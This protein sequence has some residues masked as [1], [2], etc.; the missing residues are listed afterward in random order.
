MSSPPSV[1]PSVGVWLPPVDGAPRFA[2]RPPARQVTR[3]LAGRVSTAA[4]VARRPRVG[5]V[6]LPCVVP[7]AA[8]TN[9]MCARREPRAARFQWACGG[10]GAMSTL[11]MHP[12]TYW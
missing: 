5:V 10:Y 11:A 4:A 9:D 12:R 1:R 8:N 7:R 3:V 2:A 6:P